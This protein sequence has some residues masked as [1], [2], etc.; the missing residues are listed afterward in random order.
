MCKQTLLYLGFVL[1]LLMYRRIGVVIDNIRINRKS[2]CHCETAV[3]LFFLWPL[4]VFSVC[5]RLRWCVWKTRWS[6]PT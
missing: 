3:S 1:V 6:E 4:F 5:V 2:S